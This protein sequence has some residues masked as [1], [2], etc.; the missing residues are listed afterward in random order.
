MMPAIKYLSILLRKKKLDAM[1]VST[2][3]NVTYLTGFRGAESLLI[4]DKFTRVFLLTDFRYEQQAKKELP[5][6]IKVIC[7]KIGLIRYVPIFLQEYSLKKVAFE[8]ANLTF[9]A[10]QTLYK[11]KGKCVFTPFPEVIEG[12]REIKTE[13]ELEKLQEVVDI[14]K[15]ALNTTR[16][17]IRAGMTEL[18]VAGFLEYSMK[19]L[20]AQKSSFSTIVASGENASM[21]HAVTSSR[22]IKNNEPIIIDCGSSLNGYNSDLTITVFLGRINAQY[23]NIYNTIAT[24][25][26]RAISAVRP[27]VKISAIDKIARDYLA[28]KDLDKY[29]GHATGHGIG[30]E[31]HEAPRISSK[32]NTLLRANMVFTVEPGI[33]I[34][35]WG[36]IRL[37]NMV[38]VTNKSHRV[39]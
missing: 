30:L 2:P 39:L 35:G 9:E 16:K 38:V 8:S 33:Y 10:V 18:E 5:S 1:L 19:K 27:G 11:A 4:V 7:V 22:R 26:R 24:A 13:K 25:Q 28:S 32:N 17:Y 31:V 12:L 23:S 37:E 15:K 20:G 3:A 34:P 36:G 29:F 21:P 6:Q 14:T